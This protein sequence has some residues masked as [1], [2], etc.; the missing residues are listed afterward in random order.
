[1]HSN[2]GLLGEHALRELCIPGTHDAGMSLLDGGTAGSTA[3]N[4][5]TQTLSI[6][7]QLHCGS[8]YF[9]I[10]PVI[11]GGHF[12]TGHYSLI[13]KAGIRTWQGSNGQSI[14]SII[15][16]VNNFTDHAAELVI[17]DLSHDLNTDVGNASYSPL[18][19]HDWDRLLSELSG[20]H[21]LYE[22]PPGTTD[23]TRLKLRD[24]IGEQRS[25]V[26]VIV[27]PSQE[28]IGLGPLANKGFYTSKQFAIYN[29][30]SNSNNLNHMVNDQLTK[31]RQ[32]RTGPDSG[33]FL[34]S[35]TLTQDTGQTIVG[36][37]PGVVG[38]VVGVFDHG[39]HKSILDL[40]N[41]ANAQLF[42]QLLP[43]CSRNCYPNIIYIDNF[44]S[45]DVAAMALAVNC[46]AI[47]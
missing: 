18:T 29:S 11:S 25:A 17:L 30:Y 8:R 2:L 16:D 39:I 36:A 19:Q 20:L 9:D 47:A 28:G 24:F 42:D 31:M 7:N 44:C 34:L 6:L 21:H 27:E 46:K 5:K 45:G 41:E 43:A 35:W 3:E 15:N 23:L 14:Q 13:E 22:A 37:L 4:T 1:M 40:A 10:R 12:K 38:D 33:Y 26:V 32:Q